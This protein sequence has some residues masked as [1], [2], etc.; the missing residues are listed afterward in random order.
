M[1]SNE[2]ARTKNYE[3]CTISKVPKSVTSVVNKNF[4]FR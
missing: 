1:E 2:K 4:V 3:A